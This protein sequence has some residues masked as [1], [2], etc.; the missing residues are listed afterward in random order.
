[1]SISLHP[2]SGLDKGYG[3]AEERSISECAKIADEMLMERDK[4]F[5]VDSI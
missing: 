5:P 4:R 2:G 1:M 3:K